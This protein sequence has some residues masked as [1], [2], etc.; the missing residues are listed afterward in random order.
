MQSVP[1][2]TAG[3]HAKH[4]RNILTLANGNDNAVQ[5][6]LDGFRRGLEKPIGTYY[7]GVDPADVALHVARSTASF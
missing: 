3:S 4:A 6:G 5:V 7:Q 1:R 2:Y